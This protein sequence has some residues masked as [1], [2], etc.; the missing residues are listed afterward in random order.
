MAF[1]KRLWRLE[2]PNKIKLFLW[3]AASDILPI[4]VNLFTRKVIPSPLCSKCGKEGVST[5]HA[6]W[7]CNGNKQF[8]PF[9][10]F[11]IG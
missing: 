1:W 6:L 4:A 10:R 7:Q 11:G 5:M 8:W 9:F 2:I 3:R